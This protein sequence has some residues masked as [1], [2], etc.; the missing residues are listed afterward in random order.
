[1]QGLNMR[2]GLAATVTLGNAGCGFAGILVLALS[3]REAIP[4]AIGLI[5]AAWLCDTFDGMVARRLGVAGPFGAVLDSVCDV[6]SFG[7]LPALITVIGATDAIP[8]LVAAASSGLYLAAA[9][10]RLS[11]YTVKAVGGASDDVRLWFEGLSS[12]A[13][14]MAVGATALALPAWCSAMTAIGGLLMVSSVPYPDL[15]KFYLRRAVPLWT[16]ALPAACAAAFAW[17]TVLLGCFI[18][19]IVAAPVVFR[20]MSPAPLE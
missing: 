15:T 20:R 16:L 7:V 4:T 3:G 17:T 6:I 10:L 11:R 18:F 1:M 14:A 9:L 13:A 2:T 8:W 12:P 19:Y 5:F